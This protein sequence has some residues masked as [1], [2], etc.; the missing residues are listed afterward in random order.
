MYKKASCTCKVV[1]LLLDLPM[2]FSPF[3]LPLS[4][5]LKLPLTKPR[6]RRQWERQQ[7]IG[8]RSKTS[9]LHGHHVFW[10]IS[11][12]SL[13]NYDV[14][15]SNYKLTVKRERQ[16]D[17]FYH[18]CLNS[19]AVPSLSPNPTRGDKV[20]SSYF[21]VPFTYE[22]SYYLRVWNRLRTTI[23]DTQRFDGKRANETKSAGTHRSSINQ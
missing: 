12:P 14:K 10:F 21:R 3:S 20:K 16:G 15:W 11:L 2:A 5:L 23:L 6:R 4:S 9:T 18:L 8:L 19:G 17:K 1:V 22:S 7:A 13:H